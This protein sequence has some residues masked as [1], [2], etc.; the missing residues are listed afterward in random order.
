MRARPLA[1]REERTE[2][3]PLVAMR[4]RKPCFLARLR[5]FGWKVRFV[6]MISLSGKDLSNSNLKYLS[7]LLNLILSVKASKPKGI[8]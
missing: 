3:P 5:L 2:R 4:A 8:S 7:Y 1:R 6:V